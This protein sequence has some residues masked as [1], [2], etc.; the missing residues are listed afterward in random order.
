MAPKIAIVYVSGARSFARLALGLEQTPASCYSPRNSVGTDHQQ[1]SMY[2][3][4]KALAEAEKR[5]IEA[6][7][8][9]ASIFQ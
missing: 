5:G 9:Q 6:A 8:G 4:I 2:G 1:Y 3:H 7:G